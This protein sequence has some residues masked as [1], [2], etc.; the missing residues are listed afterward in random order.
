MWFFEPHKST[1]YYGFHLLYQ[2]H[3]RDLFDGPVTPSSTAATSWEA[4]SHESYFM[5]VIDIFNV[6]PTL[7][8]CDGVRYQFVRSI[9]RGKRKGEQVPTSCSSFQVSGKKQRT[10]C[11]QLW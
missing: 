7:L 3:L 10:E 9:Q 8:V 1:P 6:L 4:I 2:N 5:V 11:Y